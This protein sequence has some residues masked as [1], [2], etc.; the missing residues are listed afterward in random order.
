MDENGD[1]QMSKELELLYDKIVQNNQM[2]RR[3]TELENENGMLKTKLENEVSKLKCQLLIEQNRCKIL[4]RRSI[5]AKN[6]DQEDALKE[7]VKKLKRK[8]KDLKGQLRRRSTEA[9]A[10]DQKDAVNERVEKLKRKVKDLK[11]QL[12]CRSTEAEAASHSGRGTS[13]RRISARVRAQNRR[14]KNK[15]RSMLR[16]IE[17]FRCV[18]CEKIFS[19]KSVYIRHAKLNQPGQ[20]YKCEV[21]S[22]DAQF[23]YRCTLDKHSLQHTASIP[24][25]DLM[26]NTSIVK[27]K[28][29]RL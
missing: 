3:I 16:K 6:G 26:A 22:C 8:V 23:T 13:T 12:R 7:R 19:S 27:I 11:D 25:S 15:R 2:A 4:E 21:D 20:L 14:N 5:E 18:A 10:G 17:D 24:H 1:T 28:I 9:E 29:E